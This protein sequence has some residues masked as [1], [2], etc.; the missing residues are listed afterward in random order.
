MSGGEISNNKATDGGGVYIDSDFNMS[1]GIIS[2]NK[3][4]NSGGGVYIGSG[5]FS[6]TEG[7]LSGNTARVGN[8]V[9]PTDGTDVYP[10][11]GSGWLFGDVSNLGFVMGIVVGVSVVGVV[12]VV[13]FVYS[14]KTR[15]N[16][17]RM[18]K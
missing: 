8:N 5:R 2:G 6:L 10:D 11:D 16:R 3:A 1:G 18:I 14:R 4:Y 15:V 7:K 9:Y 12:G 13:L 17:R